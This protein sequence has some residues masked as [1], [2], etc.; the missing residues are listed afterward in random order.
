V[1]VRKAS[2][3]DL[4]GIVAYGREAT[5]KTAYG[6]FPYNATNTRR[7]V[8]GAIKAADMEVWVTVIDGKVRGVLIGSIDLL[9]MS[10]VLMA[11]DMAFAAEAG[12][13]LL[14]DR[15]IAW[16]K[17]RGAALIEMC[18]SQEHD[19]E[20]FGKLL[21]RKGFSRSGGVYRML[22]RK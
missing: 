5:A 4:S 14:L 1:I 6:I 7:F 15:F 21:E 18:S 19:Y 9:L 22:L 10:H 8:Q 11:C 3:A 12:G 17:Q 2:I 13:D 16:A 20:R